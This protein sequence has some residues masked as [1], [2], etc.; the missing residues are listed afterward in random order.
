MNL[1]GHS[2]TAS[3]PVFAQQY[4]STS[5]SHCPL[6]PARKISTPFQKLLFQFVLFSPCASEVA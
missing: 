4:S 2:K 3:P 6:I 1:I 5:S